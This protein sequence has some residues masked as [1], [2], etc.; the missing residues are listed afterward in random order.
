MNATFRFLAVLAFFVLAGCVG[1]VDQADLR[2]PRTEAEWRDYHDLRGPINR[3]AET[4]RVANLDLCPSP[5]WMELNVNA[6]S[7]IGAFANQGAIYI[8]IPLLKFL[9][10]DDERSV[11]VGHEWAHILLRHKKSHIPSKAQEL[12][13]QADCLGAI[14]AMRA[15]YDTEKGAVLDRRMATLPSNIALSLLSLGSAGK[16]FAESER[17]VVDAARQARGRPITR[18]TIRSI[19]GV[20]P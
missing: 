8:S 20:A 5:C 10:N 4:I 15:G 9:K 14:L 19:C 1:V 11:I 7:G 3:V 17:R 6:A 18:E 2:T 12:E 16:S 13:R